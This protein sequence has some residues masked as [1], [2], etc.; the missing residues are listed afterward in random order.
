MLVGA[1]T[2]IELAWAEDSGGLALL[3]LLKGNVPAL[4]CLIVADPEDLCIVVRATL[5]VVESKSTSLVPASIIDHCKV[6]QGT[7]PSLGRHGFAD[8]HLCSC[9][10]DGQVI[11]ANMIVPINKI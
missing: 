11:I 6:I 3:Q 10:R 9:L 7:I 5:I 4:R 1:A 8:L 2:L